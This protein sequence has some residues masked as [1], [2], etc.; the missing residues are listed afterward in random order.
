MR[1]EFDRAY[2]TANGTVA[3]LT[4]N[5]PDVLNAASA[6]MVRGMIAALDEIEKKENGFRALILTGEGRAFCSGAN[7]AEPAEGSGGAAAM[8]EGIFHPLLRRLRDLPMPLVTA[9]NGSAAGLGMSLALM[10][11][12]VMAARSA[13]FLQAFAR[14][15]LVPD[16]GSTWLL[17]RRI[18]LARAKE[19]SML[20]EK[21]PAQ[22]AW[23]WG[24]I[25][26][27]CDDQ[28]LADEALA[29]A[30]RLASGPTVALGLIRKLYRE[31]P[32]NSF[33]QQLAL[34]AAAQDSAASTEDF[35]EGLRAFH[36]KRPTE[37][38]GR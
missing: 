9:V 19:L 33:E 17:P 4:M 24:L 10:G 3:V 2:L 11:D 20:A 1:K 36:G 25:N 6:R 15:G 27:V 5:H 12:L 32:E 14:I 18:G 21:L 30:A 16:G 38:K 29:L 7:L 28:S 26:R 35:R 23:E 13:Y 34:E 31:S 8:L 37:F 22:R